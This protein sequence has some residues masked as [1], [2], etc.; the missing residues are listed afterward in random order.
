MKDD[1][2]LC[3]CGNN[4]LDVEKSTPNWKAYHCVCPKCGQRSE[5]AK[6]KFIEIAMS[7]AKRKK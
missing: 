4:M 2:I 7:Q 6:N 5:A 3:E 1:E